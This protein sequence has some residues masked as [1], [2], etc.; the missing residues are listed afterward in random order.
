MSQ[1]QTSED[2]HTSER[3][4]RSVGVQFF[5][6]RDKIVNCEYSIDKLRNALLVKFPM[7]S[8]VGD[9]FKMAICVDDP[10]I[11]VFT[12]RVRSSELANGNSV[13]KFLREPIKKVGLHAILKGLPGNEEGTL[14]GL[15][16]RFD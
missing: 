3:K 8:E 13:D 6:K 2:S 12:T 1:Q 7:D 16:L 15:E 5:S 14:S 4:V 9:T 11:S 10:E